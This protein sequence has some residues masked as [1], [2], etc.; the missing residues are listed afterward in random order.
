VD[1]A[2]NILGQHRGLPFYTVGQRRGLGLA[3]GRPCYVVDIDHRHNRLVVGPER[4]LLGRHLWA[5]RLNWISIE[6]PLRPCSCAVQIRY[7]HI[8]APAQVI[9]LPDGDVHIEFARSQRAITPGQSA[10]FYRRDEILGG[11]IICLSGRDDV[12]ELL[13]ECS[14]VDERETST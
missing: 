11:G 7:R 12:A 2:G 3:L 8:A 1:R 6:P 5:G 9:P 10:V 4:E 13:P 14:A